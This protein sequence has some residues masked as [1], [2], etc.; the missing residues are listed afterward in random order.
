MKLCQKRFKEIYRE[1]QPVEVAVD[2]RV[3]GPGGRAGMGLIE[4]QAPAQPMELAAW[5]TP[6]P[7]TC[8]P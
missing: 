1:R 2:R 7:W 3:A 8:T 6:V 4:A 5:I